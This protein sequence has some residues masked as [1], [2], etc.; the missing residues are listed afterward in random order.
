[1]LRITSKILHKIHR[2][3][4]YDVTLTYAQ[5][6]SRTTYVNDVKYDGCS[7]VRT[8]ALAA[9]PIEVVYLYAGRTPYVND[10]YSCDGRKYVHESAYLGHLPI[11]RVN[12]W[13]RP[14]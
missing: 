14:A 6:H 12:Q 4:A 9:P 5:P 2:I 7:D 3:T 10:V 13:K 1:M 8:F 11:R